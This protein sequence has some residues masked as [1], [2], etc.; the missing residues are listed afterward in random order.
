MSCH[1]TS[2]FAE[3]EELMIFD[4]ILL[5]GTRQPP[6]KSCYSSL[7]SLLCHLK[8]ISI[9]QCLFDGTTSLSS[10]TS[11]DSPRIFAGPS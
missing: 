7:N 4:I 10:L 3:L 5:L 6:L 8:F 2:D 9:L 11:V 1:V